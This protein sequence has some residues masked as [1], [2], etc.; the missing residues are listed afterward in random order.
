MSAQNPI[1]EEDVCTMSGKWEG[2]FA[3]CQ[4]ARVRRKALRAD[5][6]GKQTPSPPLHISGEGRR[7]DSPFYLD[8]DAWH[9]LLQIH[10]LSHDLGEW[11]VSMLTVH[12]YVKQQVT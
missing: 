1:T 8:A 4:R 5:V 6:L 9:N 2:N 10:F 7:G 3:G 12:S 11:E